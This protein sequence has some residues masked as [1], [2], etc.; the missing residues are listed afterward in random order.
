MTLETPAIPGRLL[1]CALALLLACAARAQ[2]ATVTLSRDAITTADRLTLEVAFTVAPGWRLDPWIDGAR[3]ALEQ[4]GWTVVSA[5]ADAPALASETEGAITHRARFLLE[6]FLE[7]DYAIPPL[8]ADAVPVRG[9]P[10]ELTTPARTVP[11]ASVLPEDEP[12]RLPMPIDAEA[13]ADNADAPDA[14]A[15]GGST[16]ADAPLGVLRPVPDEPSDGA[17]R[18]ALI[19]SAIAIMGAG[20]AVLVAVRSARTPRVGRAPDPVREIERLARATDPDLALIYRHLRELSRRPAG[21]GRGDLDAL[22]ARLECARYAP[23]PT[24]EARA[25]ADEALRLAR[26]VDRTPS[27]AGG[28]SDG[29]GVPA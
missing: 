5:T 11:V 10:V 27:F 19:G 20:I 26:L 22:I 24:D 25:I 12:V 6:P 23:E 28:P 4:A 15:A 14:P 13:S 9:E 3:S 2:D 7:G 8:S 29:E 16:E 21:R 18:L 17:P 1:A